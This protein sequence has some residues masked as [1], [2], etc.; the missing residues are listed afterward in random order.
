MISLGASVGAF[1]AS[2]GII[3]KA[4]WTK[5]NHGGDNGWIINTTSSTLIWLLV[6]QEMVRYTPGFSTNF[7][8]GEKSRGTSYSDTTYNSN[9]TRTWSSHEL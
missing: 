4:D 8:V 3:F 2:F 7:S 9:T 6:T 1:L 5:I